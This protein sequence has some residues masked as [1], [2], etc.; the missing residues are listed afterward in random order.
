MLKIT[1]LINVEVPTNGNITLQYFFTQKDNEFF[2]GTDNNSIGLPDLKRW[3]K[4]NEV[5]E[6]KNPIEL[7]EK[8]QLYIGGESPILY[9]VK[10]GESPKPF[11]KLYDLIIQQ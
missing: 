3:T 11:G 4:N 5:Y 8:E 9:K 6:L 7:D 2:F 1:H 10:K